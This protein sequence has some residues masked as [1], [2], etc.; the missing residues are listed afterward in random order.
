MILD[1]VLR[2]RQRVVFL[3]L[4]WFLMAAIIILRMSIL[5][6][7][8]RNIATGNQDQYLVN[9]VAHLH[10]GY[11]VAIAMVEIISSYFLLRIFAQAKK[12]SDEVAKRAGLFYYLTQ[13]TELR[14]ASLA[15]IGVTRA[16]TYSFQRTLKASDV[17]GQVDRFV[18]TFECMFPIIM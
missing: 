13:S 5:V 4:F 8:A 6:C 1:R 2:S 3:A 16:V 17:T 10:I 15:L 18:F 7:R 12:G 14:L 11:F 9:L